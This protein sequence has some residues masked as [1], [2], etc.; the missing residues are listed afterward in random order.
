[1]DFYN[2]VF[3]A[4]LQLSIV[5]EIT[6]ASCETDQRV[7]FQHAVEV[8]WAVESK[9]VVLLNAWSPRERTMRT[10]FQSLGLEVFA[11]VS[12]IDPDDDIVIVIDVGAW[13]CWDVRQNVKFLRLKCPSAAT[14]IVTGY[15]GQG[16]YAESPINTDF[17]DARDVLK[18]AGYGFFSW[19]GAGHDN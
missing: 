8:C 4:A 2:Q 5:E 12:S 6:S 17:N 18:A 11:G 7:S 13:R 14:C 16:V 15:I 1:M 19:G 10:E 9:T 3:Y